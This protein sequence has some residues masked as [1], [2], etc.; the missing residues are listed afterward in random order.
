MVGFRVQV[1]HR[2]FWPRFETNGNEIGTENLD[3]V[4]YSLHTMRESNP[5]SRADAIIAYARPRAALSALEGAFRLKAIPCIRAETDHGPRVQAR[6]ARDRGDAVGAE[7]HVAG[8]AQ[9]E[10]A[11][12]TREGGCD[13][14]ATCQVRPELG[15]HDVCYGRPPSAM[16][17]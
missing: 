10:H 12:Q 1:N 15:A 2:R 8:K 17:K 7:Q 3:V 16:S 11:G 13:W 6:A 9:V 4:Y 14:G 5:A